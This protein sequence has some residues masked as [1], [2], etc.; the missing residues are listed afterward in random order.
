QEVR[1]GITFS[2]LIL[3]KWLGVKPDEDKAFE[4][5]KEMSCKMLYQ[6]G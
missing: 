6:R 1:K 5:Y 4:L 2:R 3:L